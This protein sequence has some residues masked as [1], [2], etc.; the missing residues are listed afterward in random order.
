MT[1]LLY[2]K[3]IQTR[4]ILTLISESV[5]E[6]V[7]KLIYTNCLPFILDCG[8]IPTPTTPLIVNGTRPDI[9]EFPWH[10]TLYMAETPDARKEFICGA[11]IIKDNLLITAAHCIYD[12]TNRKAYEPDKF[13]IATGNVFQDYDSLLHHPLIVRKAQV[14][15]SN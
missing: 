11:T 14:I 13:Y 6:F 10:A 4:T 5:P 3:I 9:T 1:K 7:N 2:T 8:K 12:E 15:K